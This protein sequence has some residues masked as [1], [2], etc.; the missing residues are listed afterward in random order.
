M[1]ND[2]EK[3]VGDLGSE[4]YPIRVTL[5]KFNGNDIIDI[6]KF[7][8]DKQ[9]EL[10]PTKKGI[11]LTRTTLYPLLKILADNLDDIN[12]FFDVNSDPHEFNEKINQLELGD[13]VLDKLDSYKFYEVE[14]LNAENLVK[15]DTNHPFGTKVEALRDKIKSLDSN[16]GIELEGLFKVLF[17]S[18]Y[19]AKTH[20]DSDEYY[21][22]ES[23]FTDHEISWSIN[24]K[25]ELRDV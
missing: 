22:A 21:S 3:N 13:L 15:I 18:H 24:I 7:Y 17:K 10:K 4:N 11:S 19:F 9:G 23:L 8:K 2:K 5:R 20:F 1:D 6:R 14:N 25:R 16:L 12:E